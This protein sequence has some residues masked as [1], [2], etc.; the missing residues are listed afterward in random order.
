MVRAVAV[1]QAARP[2]TLC[3]GVAG[4]LAQETK[5]LQHTLSSPSGGVL[6]LALH[7]PPLHVSCPPSLPSMSPAPGPG[8][9]RH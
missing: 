5:V 7:T 2:A 6:V 8:R 3:P 9:S 4:H 1:V